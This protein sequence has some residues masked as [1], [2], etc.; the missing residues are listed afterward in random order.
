MKRVVLTGLL[1]A[2]GSMMVQASERGAQQ[3]MVAH[4]TGHLNQ[5]TAI[6]FGAGVGAEEGM[7][8]WRPN[9]NEAN[10]LRDVGYKA[11][12]AATLGGTVVAGACPH[13]VVRTVASAASV[14]GMT[15]MYLLGGKKTASS[16]GGSSN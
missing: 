7:R 15:T 16:T 2:S 10:S 3:G 6:A 1:L 5:R 11:G 9:N 13:N 4:V 12:Q 8:K 14:L